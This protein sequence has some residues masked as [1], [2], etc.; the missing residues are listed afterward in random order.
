MCCGERATLG[1]DRQ[2][3]LEA[4]YGSVEEGLL[5]EDHERV[6]VKSARLCVR[7]YLPCDGK[8]LCD[9]CRAREAKK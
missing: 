9:D 1:I 7:R 6:L 5:R 3:E 4:A 8:T 2:E